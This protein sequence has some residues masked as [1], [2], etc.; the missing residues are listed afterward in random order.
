MV[1]SKEKFLVELS[2]I[3]F[4]YIDATYDEIYSTQNNYDYLDEY[5]LLKPTLNELIKISRISGASLTEAESNYEQS[6][7]VFLV[8]TLCS[9]CKKSNEP[10]MLPPVNWYYLINSLIKSKHG[11]QVES[12]LLEI[13]IMQLKD[14]QS[15][16]SILKNYLIDTNYFLNLKP[17]TQ[18]IVFENFSLICGRLNIALLRKFLSKL[19]NF[20]QCI[21]IVD[22]KT[23]SSDEKEVSMTNHFVNILKNLHE[24]FKTQRENATELVNTEMVEFFYFISSEFEFNCE[25]SVEV[26]HV[27]VTSKIHFLPNDSIEKLH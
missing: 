17:T 23:T 20:L 22:T 19:K 13:C 10:H 4:G 27:W 11:S 21:E 8:N 18:S 6:K 3:Y 16:Y 1:P 7:F 24:Y 26:S 15:A 12:K 5:S 2:Y 25:N 14:S 9:A